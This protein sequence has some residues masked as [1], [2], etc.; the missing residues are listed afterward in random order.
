MDE[1][2]QPSSRAIAVA[3]L[4]HLAELPGGVDVQQRE[5][6][7]ARIERLHRQVQHHALSLPIE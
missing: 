5:R 3:E 1:Q 4:D 6:R 7:L 2:L